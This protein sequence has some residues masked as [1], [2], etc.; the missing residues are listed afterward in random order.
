A[1]HK[2]RKFL[3]TAGRS[4]ESATSLTKQLLTFAKGGDPIKET[5]SIGAVIAETAQFSLRGS[6]VKLQTNIAPDLWPVEAD[7]GQLSQVIS[8]LVINA[9]QAMPDGGTITIS[10]EN[11]ANPAG[12]QVQITV[13]DEG[14]GISSQYLDR[15]FDPYFS[16]KQQ[17]SGLGLASTYSI[18][19]KHNGTINAA[20]ILNEGTNFTICLPVAEEEEK[21]TTEDLLAETDN[22]PLVAAHIL[23]LDD[24]ELVREVI[25]AMLEELG[26]KVSYAVH[27][28][29]AIKKYQEAWQNNS[30]YDAVITDLTIPGGMG[31]QEAAQEILKTDPQ[32][33]IIV[34]S[35]YA[36]DPVM[37]NYKDY[38]FQGRVVK[39]YHFAELKKVIERVLMG[40]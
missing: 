38:G 37:A 8:N 32:A 39:P 29:E 3:E 14:I 9:Q 28:R 31:G 26:H 11:V 18:I 12:R 25:G 4:M 10:V 7:K 1:D 19:T 6:N 35:G 24:E 27:G 13:G 36:T 16:T 5:L 2:S 40:T 15:I 30:P 33:K 17:G 22:T 23:I 34:S 21:S 20:S